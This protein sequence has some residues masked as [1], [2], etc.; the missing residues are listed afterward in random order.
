[1]DT[2]IGFV[3]FD[4]IPADWTEKLDAWLYSLPE[5]DPLNTNFEASG[6][7]SLFMIS[8]IGLTKW[9]CFVNIIIAAISYIL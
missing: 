2:I 9:I 7:E 3:T 1:M 5:T 4:P 8:N 6:Y